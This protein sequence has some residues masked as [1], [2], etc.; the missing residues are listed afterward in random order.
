M[1]ERG[2]L[3]RA[4]FYNLS[5]FLYVYTVVTQNKVWAGQPLH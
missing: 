1:C 3:V 2:G 5:V 4:F